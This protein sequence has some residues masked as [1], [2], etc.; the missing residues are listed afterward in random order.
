MATTKV[1]LRIGG[2][3]FDIELDSEFAASITPEI[4]HI[5]KQDVNN[6]IKQLLQAYIKKSYELYE[7]K[8]VLEKSVEKLETLRE[9]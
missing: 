1:N 2:S 3:N 8:K 4:N 5:F 7:L 9:V 6:D